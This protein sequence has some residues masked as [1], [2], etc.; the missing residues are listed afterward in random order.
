[1]FEMMFFVTYVVEAHVSNRFHCRSF[2]HLV[3]TPSVSTFLSP[4]SVLV[5]TT[6]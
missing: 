4:V 1:M 6:E 3:M 5:V 2:Q